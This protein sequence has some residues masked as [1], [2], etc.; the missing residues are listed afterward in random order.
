MFARS[1]SPTAA[2]N[3]IVLIGNAGLRRQMSFTRGNSHHQPMSIADLQAGDGGERPWSDCQNAHIGMGFSQVTYSG[4]LDR[5]FIFAACF[6][7]NRPESC[8]TG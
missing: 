1:R 8:A 4:C 5:R 2:E 3:S 7:K 6:K